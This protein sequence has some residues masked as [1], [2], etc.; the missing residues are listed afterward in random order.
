MRPAIRST[1][2]IVAWLEE[3]G[4]QSSVPLNSPTLMKLLYLSQAIYASEHNMAKLMPATFLAT[5]AGP[6]EPDLF[7]AMEHGVSLDDPVSP[8]DHVEE[9]L[10]A[11]WQCHVEK[12]AEEFEKITHSDTAIA[13]AKEKGRNSEILVKDMAEAYSGGI[14]AFLGQGL[15]NK[16]PDGTTYDVKHSN[17]DA[18]PSENQEV[19]FTADGRSVTKWVPKRR[20]KSKD[21]KPTTKL[22]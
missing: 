22:H 15:A 1:F 16:F 21:L 2:D 10:L 14:S 9:V 13:K 12:S 6:I 11:I 20:I 5:D 8:S 19:R 7:I 3:R 17:L 18:V 4:A